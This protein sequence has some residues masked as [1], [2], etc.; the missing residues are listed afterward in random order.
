MPEV[1]DRVLEVVLQTA[2][3]ENGWLAIRSGDF[4]IIKANAGCE[5]CQGERIN[6]EANPLMREI[7]NSR[8][9]RLVEKAKLNGP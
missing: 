2:I 1:L 5:E 9:A 7:T 3:C 8:Q 6:I 4:F